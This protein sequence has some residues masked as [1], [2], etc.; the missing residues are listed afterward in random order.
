VWTLRITVKLGAP[1]SQVVGEQKVTLTLPEGATLEDVL[2][3]LRADYPEF[4]VGLR[5]KGLRQPLDQVLYQLFLNAQP[6]PF[7]KAR[8]TQLRDGDRIYLFLPVAG[9]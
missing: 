8:A 1:L 9:G 5:G 2:D 6:V 4:E 7:D 3:R